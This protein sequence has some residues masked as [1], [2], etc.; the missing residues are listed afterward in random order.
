MVRQ[1]VMAFSMVF[2]ENMT[3]GDGDHCLAVREAVKD[4]VKVDVDFLG[5]FRRHSPKATISFRL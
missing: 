2:S 1:V 5:V 4:V 3:G